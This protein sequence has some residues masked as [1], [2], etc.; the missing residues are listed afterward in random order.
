LFPDEHQ[1]IQAV[2]VEGHNDAWR[3]VRLQGHI[4]DSDA[5]EPHTDKND[6]DVSTATELPGGTI[7]LQEHL[8]F[9]RHVLQRLRERIEQHRASAASVAT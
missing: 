9:E 5:T 2:R 7:S 3:E 1:Q 8:D 4:I 6:T